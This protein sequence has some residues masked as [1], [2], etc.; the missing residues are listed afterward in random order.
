[1]PIVILETRFGG[2]RGTLLAVTIFAGFLLI[3]PPSYRA[4]FPVW[5]TGTRNLPRLLLFA[6][7]DLVYVVSFGIVLPHLCT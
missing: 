1:M 7:L 2:V 4:L 6:L 5:A 3:G